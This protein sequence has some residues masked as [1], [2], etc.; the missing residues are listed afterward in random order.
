[1]FLLLKVEF[2][3]FLS[4]KWLYPRLDT[5]CNLRSVQTWLYSCLW[6]R[7]LHGSCGKTT[8][9]GCVCGATEPNVAQ[10][11]FYVEGKLC[12]LCEWCNIPI[13]VNAV[14]ILNFF[15]YLSDMLRRGICSDEEIIFILQGAFGKYASTNVSRTH[16][17]SLKWNFTLLFLFL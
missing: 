4:K 3:A 1:M 17:V 8:F 6:H 14:L 7:K 11:R 9:M 16:G 15:A 12:S 2:W 5:T 10:F 13:D